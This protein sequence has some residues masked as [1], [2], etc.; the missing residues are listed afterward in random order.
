[1][2]I[3]L[4]LFFFFY[5]KV[6]NNNDGKYQTFMYSLRASWEKEGRLFCFF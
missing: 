4:F 3:F 6:N 1:M 5:L 2:L